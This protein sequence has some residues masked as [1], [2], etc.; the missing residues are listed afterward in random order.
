MTQPLEPLPPQ[1]LHL[2]AEPSGM[3]PRLALRVRFED[4]GFLEHPT[5]CQL[6]ARLVRSGASAEARKARRQQQP[7]LFWPSS[8]DWQKRAGGPVELCPPG[9]APAQGL[10]LQDV[11]GAGGLLAR[12]RPLLWQHE[13]P[14][15][16]SAAQER[17]ADRGHGGFRHRRRGWPSLEAPSGAAQ[18]LVCRLGLD[19]SAAQGR[20]ERGD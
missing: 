12:A 1:P 19:N 15:A 2:T 4:G 7:A 13:G 10:L 17:G 18:C 6:R 14:A 8:G 20:G 11:P 16:L 3:L 5:T 9:E